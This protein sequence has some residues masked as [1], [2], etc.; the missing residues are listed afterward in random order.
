MIHCPKIPFIPTRPSPFVSTSLVQSSTKTEWFEVPSYYLCGLIL[1]GLVMLGLAKVTV[2]VFAQ[3]GNSYI[4]MWDP[5][6]LPLTLIN[7][8][9]MWFLLQ[10]T[11]LVP[12]PGMSFCCVSIAFLMVRPLFLYTKLHIQN[13]VCIP[14]RH[15]PCPTFGSTVMILQLCVGR[16][17]ASRW[18]L[19]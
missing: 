5:P 18:T 17:I 1:L 2:F 3:L 9:L 4:S 7:Q 14:S 13:M 15:V 16:S 19:P 8:S 6:K 12:C 10:T 11:T